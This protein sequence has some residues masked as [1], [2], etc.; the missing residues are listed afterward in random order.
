VGAIRDAKT[1]ELT[2]RQFH[3]V[4]PNPIDDYCMQDIKDR[5]E[6]PPRSLARATGDDFAMNVLP[7]LVEY[8]TDIQTVGG[9]GKPVRI[10][11]GPA[12]VTGDAHRGVPLRRRAA[13]DPPT[14][15]REGAEG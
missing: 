14:A 15:G 12:T 9:E 3:S 6:R 10:R 1:G 2:S 4:P 5:D 13:T 8:D 7:Q 11:R